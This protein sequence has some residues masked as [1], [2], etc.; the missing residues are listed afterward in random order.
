MHTVQGII[1]SARFTGPNRRRR[2]KETEPGRST[3]NEIDNHA[4]TICAGSNWKLLKLSGE[5]CNVSPFST[6]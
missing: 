3:M 1:S 4:D 2:P 5:Y 6:D